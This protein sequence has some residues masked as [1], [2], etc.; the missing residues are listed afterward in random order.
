[1]L[2]SKSG[3]RRVCSSLVHMPPNPNR[4]LVILHEIHNH[5]DFSSYLKNNSFVEHLLQE[6]NGA[7]VDTK[8]MASKQLTS[9]VV[10]LAKTLAVATKWGYSH[11]VCMSLWTHSMMELN[12]KSIALTL[13]TWK[14]LV[15]H[16]LLTRKLKLSV[17][18]QSDKRCLAS[19]RACQRSD[20]LR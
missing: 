7:G 1:M 13:C 4:V 5:D 6:I 14:L 16:R 10:T 18:G 17:G 19:P 20:L 2:W 12:T 8:L 11:F 3:K 9:P 15:R